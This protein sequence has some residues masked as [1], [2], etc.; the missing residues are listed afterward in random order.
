MDRSLG[1]LWWVQPPGKSKLVPEGYFFAEGGSYLWVVPSRQLVIVH[2]RKS[3]LVVLR[4]KLGLLP[5]EEKV[6]EIFQK[7]VEAAPRAET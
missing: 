5:D 7:I 2:H 1:V 6:W 3:N 4:S